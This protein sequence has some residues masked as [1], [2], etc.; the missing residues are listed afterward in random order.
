MWM[1][2]KVLSFQDHSCVQSS[3]SKWRLGGT[4]L[5]CVGERSEPMISALG[6]R[7]AKSLVCVSKVRVLGGE[8]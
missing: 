8:R 6:K 4:H 2:S 3:I 1:K 7:S 5:G